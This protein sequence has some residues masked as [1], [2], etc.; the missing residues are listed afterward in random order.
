MGWVGV[1]P[2]TLSPDMDGFEDVLSVRYRF[3]NEGWTASVIIVDAAG[4][5][6]RHLA[7]NAL[8][9][10]EGVFQWDGIDD[11]SNRIPTGIYYLVF[12]AVDMRGRRRIWRKA[13]V[14]AYRR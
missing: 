1:S 14:L 4:R 9:G 10:T 6:L 11:G 12:E 3:P 2:S 13:L 5:P 7:R 8:C